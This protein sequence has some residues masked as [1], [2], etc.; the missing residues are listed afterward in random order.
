MHTQTIAEDFITS[1]NR[2][3]HA[4]GSALMLKVSS[5]LHYRC[6]L[7]LHFTVITSPSQGDAYAI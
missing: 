5:C 6:Q 2:A 3:I 4:M 7:Q 1:Q